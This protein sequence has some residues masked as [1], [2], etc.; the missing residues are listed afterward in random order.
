MFVKT[1]PQIERIVK[2]LEPPNF[3]EMNLVR[4]L[5]SYEEKSQELILYRSTIVSFRE[6]GNVIIHTWHRHVVSIQLIKGRWKF[7]R[8]H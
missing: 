7:F 6:N 8:R 4:F 2:F 5:G 3:G 1:S